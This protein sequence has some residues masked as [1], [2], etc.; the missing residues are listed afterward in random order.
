VVALAGRTSVEVAL[1]IALVA[2]RTADIL[3]YHTCRSLGQ[4]RC[5]KRAEV[6]STYWT[7]AGGW[8][9]PCWL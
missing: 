7:G 3:G 5:R 2:G 1:G 6:S 8:K 9:P 4:R